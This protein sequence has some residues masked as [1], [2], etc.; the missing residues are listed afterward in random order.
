MEMTEA[1]EATAPPA[2]QTGE[3]AQADVKAKPERAEAA[4]PHQT[5]QELRRQRLSHSLLYQRG[6]RRAV[7]WRDRYGR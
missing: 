2:G 7:N 5:R 1:K 6:H 4:R 3:P